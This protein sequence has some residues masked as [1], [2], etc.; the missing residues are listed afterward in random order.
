MQAVVD[1][2]EEDMV[3]LYVLP[4]KEEAVLI[5]TS[6]FP[7]LTVGVVLEIEIRFTPPPLRRHTKSDAGAFL[8][9]LRKQL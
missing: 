1:R 4:K 5:S 3:V 9:T 6:L 7:G 8:R 2:I